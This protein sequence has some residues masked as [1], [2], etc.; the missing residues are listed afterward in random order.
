MLGLGHFDTLQMSFHVDHA[1][2]WSGPSLLPARSHVA[3]L[4]SA[5]VQTGKFCFQQNEQQHRKINES[6]SLMWQHHHENRNTHFSV[7]SHQKNGYHFQQVTHLTGKCVLIR[8]QEF[9]ED[10]IF[11]RTCLRLISSCVTP[12]VCWGP[13]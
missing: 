1:L 13:A 10:R 5:L 8:G 6:V 12:A 2:K 7:P 3:I 4:K 11:S 9:S